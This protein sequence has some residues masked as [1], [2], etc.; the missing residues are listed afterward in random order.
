MSSTFGKELGATAVCPLRKA[1]PSHHTNILTKDGSIDDSGV[2]ILHI[3]YLTKEEEVCRPG[4]E[5]IG[6]AMI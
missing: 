3:L 4:T 2:T 5:A 1:D 6:C